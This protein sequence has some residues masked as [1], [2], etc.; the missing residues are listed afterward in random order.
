MW[1]LL[2]GALFVGS[3]ISP[4]PTS[5]IHAP[6][7]SLMLMHVSWLECPFPVHPQTPWQPSKILEV[8]VSGS[9]PN[10]AC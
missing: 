2:A 7:Y 3:W 4:A 1:V 8:S 10:T 5:P 6:T 9:I